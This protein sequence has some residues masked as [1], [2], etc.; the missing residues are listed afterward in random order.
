MKLLMYLL[1]GTILSSFSARPVDDDIDGVWMGYYRST[2][3]KEKLIVK[4]SSTDKMEFYTGGVDE[5]TRL[6]GSYR[7]Q[8]DS[9]SFTYRTPEGEE[10]RMQGHFNRWKNFVNGVWKTNDK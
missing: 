4:F 7:I 5:R 10:I 8:G 2:F 3:Q 9:V 1:A 6:D